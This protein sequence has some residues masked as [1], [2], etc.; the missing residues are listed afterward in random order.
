M[1]TSNKFVLL[2][3][4][5]LL[6]AHSAA[7]AQT[8]PNADLEA[9]VRAS[10]SD[11]PDM[12]TI[13]KCESGT[14]QFNA[15]GSVLRGGAG[16]NYIGIFQID[17]RIHVPKAN[18][19]AYDIYT[20]NGNIAYARYMYFASGTNPWKGCLS[21]S[22]APAPVTPPP[23]VNPVPA[24]PAISAP[25]NGSLTVNL[26]YGISNPQVITL[27]QI[28]N[29]A[30]YVMAASGSGSPGNET[31]FYGQLTREAVKKFQCA[32]AIACNGNEST[33]GFGRVGPLTRAALNEAGK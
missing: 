5:T 6:F 9:Q 17:E 11:M 32:K 28:L 15:D 7:K 10:F 31:A 23:A 1:K 13:A 27:Q 33:T 14:R 12:V 30:G 21:G 29:K 4:F 26:D 20:I 8:S 3:L 18:S 2:A 19:M 16:K 22:S 24:S 25:V